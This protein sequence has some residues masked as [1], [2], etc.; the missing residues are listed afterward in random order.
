MSSDN[1]NGRNGN[2]LVYLDRCDLYVPQV[3]SLGESQGDS[4]L[5]II[6]IYTLRSGS[7]NGGDMRNYDRIRKIIVYTSCQPDQGHN[8][9]YKLLHLS[10]NV[11]SVRNSDR[12]G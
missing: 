8:H 3:S 7:G 6:N 10:T 4:T 9:I 5:I 2:L 11:L 1:L 12:E